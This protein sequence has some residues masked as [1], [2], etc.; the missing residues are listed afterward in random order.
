MSRKK[1][2]L[3]HSNFSKLKTG[4]GRNQKEILQYLYKT[5]KYDIVEYANA[6]VRWS[7]KNCATVPWK[8]YGA[9]PD[10]DQELAHVQDQGELRAIS[11]GS[12]NIDSVMEI[13]KPDVYI[14]VEDIW[15]FN[16]F[17]KKSWWKIVTPAL[18]TTLD[19]VPIF[20]L[21]RDHADQIPN[22]WVWASFAEREMKLL[23]HNH[24][25]TVYG[26]FP[27]EKFTPI[28]DQNKKVVRNTFGINENTVVFGFVFR[29]QLRKLVGSLLEGFALFKKKNPNTD[30]KILL[31]TNWGEGW[32]IPEF[33]KEFELNND[34]ILTTYVCANCKEI[35]VKPFTGQGLPCKLC[36]HENALN[37]PSIGLG[38]DEEQLNIIYNLMDAYVHP[39]TS[40]GLEM[41]IV[42][43]MLAGLPVST[44]GYSCGEDFT[45]NDFVHSIS[46]STYRECGSNFIKATPHSESIANFMQKVSANRLKYKEFGLKSRDW[47]LKTFNTENT[48]SFIEK[49]IDDAPF[50]KEESWNSLKKELRN[51]NYPFQDI[52]DETDWLID[53]YKNILKMEET[54]NSEGTSFWRTRLT[55]GVT[56]KQIYDFFIQTAQTENAKINSF[57]LDSFFEDNGKKRLVYIMPVSLGDC[58]LSLTIISEL[59]NIYNEDEW[60]IYVC[61]NQKNF[62]IFA[63]FSNIIK[64]LIPY[65]PE[66][67]NYK[68][69]EGAGDYK[70]VCDIAFQPYGVSQRFE[71][72]THNGTDKNILQLQ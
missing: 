19:S 65:S 57:K 17:W 61:T 43:A 38:C 47:A 40:G 3:F 29:N 48:G 36:K 66:L 20:S 26:T 13:E 1:K 45:K 69:W 49:F 37:N 72:Y 24:V 52:A 15:G 25:K 18:W 10:N 2:V 51:P 63:P 4:F 46:F 53:M 22:F 41:P 6:P 9:L 71:S 54:A 39:M 60:D 8:C 16:G 50:A 59:R 58:V 35:D 68:L 34:D 28:S 27:T 70:G 33:I 14:G 67:D 32:S 55:Q 31:H 42:E 7:D 44:V 12:Y 5:D 30:A 11:Y 21:A 56:R 64:G 23:G 62:E